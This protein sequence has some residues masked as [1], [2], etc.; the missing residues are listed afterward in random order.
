MSDARDWS[1]TSLPAA[2]AETWKQLLR[3]DSFVAGRYRLQVAEDDPQQPHELDEIYYVI[4]GSAHIDIAGTRRAVR[5]GELIFVPARVPHRFLDVT[6]PLD[7]LVVFAAAHP[8]ANPTA[9]GGPTT[10]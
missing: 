8:P 9:A 7:I 4:A 1:A 10:P 6:E 3:N 5:A 2:A